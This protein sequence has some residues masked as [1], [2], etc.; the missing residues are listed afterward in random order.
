VR[1]LY[2]PHTLGRGTDRVPVA[3]TSGELSRLRQR[4]RVVSLIG[5]GMNVASTQTSDSVLAV[6]FRGD[7]K[8]PYRKGRFLTGREIRA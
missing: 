7:T 8:R 3:A 4:V 2:H 1:I 6:A 5:E